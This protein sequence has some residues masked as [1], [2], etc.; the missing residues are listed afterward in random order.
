M[1]K[2]LAGIRVVEVAMWAF[3]PATG[4]ILSD[5][6]ADV[7]KV[8]PPSGDPLRGLTTALS[9]SSSSVD[10]SWESYNRG[11]RSITLDL[12]DAAGREVLMKLLADADV[13]L[14]NLLPRARREMQ[15][16]AQTLRASF[17][18]LV[19]AS[20][21]ALGPGGPESEKGG[22]DAITF[23]ARGGIASALTD[24][25]AERPV[26][27]PGP[28]FGDTL[29]AAMLANGICAA[30][31]KRSM[32]G[33]ASEVD[34][35][36]LGT[37]MWSM[38]RLIAQSTLDGVETFARPNSDRPNNVL[39]NN[40]RTKDNRFI[41]LCMLQA[42]KYWRPFCEVA[43]RADL[44]NDERFKSASGRRENVDA[45]VAELKA[46]FQSK[47]LIE[48]RAILSR[49]EGHWDVVQHVGEIHADAQ[50]RANHYL[51]TVDC[52]A[53]IPIPI[54]SVPT[55]FDKAA[56]PVGVSP[57]LGANSDAILAEL[58]YDE[59]SIINLKIAGVVF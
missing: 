21:S 46:L 43:G 19:Y 1:S 31:F 4:G 53:G 15:I 47:S 34:V 30:L 58:G 40:Y 6:G 5:M 38:Q 59:E 49:Q 57:A 12:K 23:W 56:L 14:T 17:P 8:E 41:A 2:P 28:A 51:Q 7:I 35:S 13:F 26:S 33:E 3:V 10:L 37:A 55:L 29:S 36:L 39:V 11:K 32:T 9:G 25:D 20:G 27:Q 42:D 24:A 50:V 18:Q 54:V 52:A 45:C 48:W 16:D 44:A 22:F